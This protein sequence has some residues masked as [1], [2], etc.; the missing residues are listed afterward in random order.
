MKKVIFILI[1]VALVITVVVIVFQN[2][3]G[4]DQQEAAD[5]TEQDPNADLRNKRKQRADK[6]AKIV[7]E[8]KGLPIDHALSQAKSEKHREFIEKNMAYQK[9]TP[10]ESLDEI[11][12]KLAEVEEEIG[13]TSDEKKLAQLNKQKEMLEKL[14]AS[15][16]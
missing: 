15:F 7:K 8:R 14:A 16:R 12:K 6:L 9:Q 5:S 4:S 1:G 11:E 10:E 2:G 13:K 3:E